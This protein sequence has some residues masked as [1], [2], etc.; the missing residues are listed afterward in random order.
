M[1]FGIRSFFTAAA[2]VL[3][4]LCAQAGRDYTFIDLDYIHTSIDAG[5]FDIDGDGLGISGSWA[6]A[7]Q[8]H[9]FGGW[10]YQEFDFDVDTHELALGAGFNTEINE[11]LDFVA[12]VALL[13]ADVEGGGDEDGFQ[14]G[15]GIRSQINERFQVDGGLTYVDLGDD[16]IVVSGKGRYFFTDFFAGTLGLELADDVVVFELGVRWELGR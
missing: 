13:H 9:L 11:Q 8:F 1:F 16:D 6:F 12:N 4:P 3:L 2:L 14:L 5:P 15:L 7:D 10:S